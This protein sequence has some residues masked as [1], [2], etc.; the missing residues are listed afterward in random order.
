MTRSYRDPDKA[1]GRTLANIT[2]DFRGKYECRRFDLISASQR[3][4]ESGKDDNSPPNPTGLADA[5]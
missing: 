3:E 2:R 4:H 1:I 5:G